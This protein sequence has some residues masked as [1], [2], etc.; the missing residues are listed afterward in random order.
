VV[1]VVELVVRP[2][3]AAG[4]AEACT[5]VIEEPSLIVAAGG[6]AADLGASRAG[7]G[8]AGT[9]ASVVANG[10]GAGELS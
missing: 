5:S 2:G 9:A 6:I 7:A 8:A 10:V 1:V 4:A 3:L